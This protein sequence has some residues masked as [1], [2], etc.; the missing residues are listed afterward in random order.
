MRKKISITIVMIVVLSIAS[1]L[2]F[3]LGISWWKAEIISI[4]SGIAVNAIVFFIEAIALSI[5]KIA[6][7]RKP[8][9]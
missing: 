1:L 6:N 9:A 7:V 3:P 2:A 8:N 5:Q 4:C